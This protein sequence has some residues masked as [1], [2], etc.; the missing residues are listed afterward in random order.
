[1]TI[2]K[3]FFEKRNIPIDIIKS[4]TSVSGVY[5]IKEIATSYLTRKFIVEPAFGTDERDWEKASPLELEFSDHLKKIPF[6][7]LNA[8]YDLGL[9]PQG[10]FFFT[11]I[12]KQFYY[13]KN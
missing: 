9:E 13:K 10:K 6:F 4:V 8:E 12:S 5:S 1:M 2:E 3:T 7:L 11:N